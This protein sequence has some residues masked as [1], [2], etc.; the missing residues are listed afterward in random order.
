MLGPCAMGWL[1]ENGRHS[2]GREYLQTEFQMLGVFRQSPA[3]QANLPVLVRVRAD[4]DHVSNRQCPGVAGNMHDGI[5]LG[6]FVGHHPGRYVD[7]GCFSCLA[8]LPQSVDAG[9]EERPVVLSAAQKAALSRIAPASREADQD[10]A[11]GRRACEVRQ[12][13]LLRGDACIEL[14]DLVLEQQ[15]QAKARKTIRQVCW[16]RNLA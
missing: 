11:S 10:A 6:A 14:G 3:D 4:G 8:K 15:A 2:L 13:Q 5:A 9:T 12:V 16:S 1:R 7:I